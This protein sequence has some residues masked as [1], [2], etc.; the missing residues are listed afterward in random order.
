LPFVEVL[1]GCLGSFGQV[2]LRRLWPA[3]G[4]SWSFGRLAIQLH[5]YRAQGEFMSTKLI[6]I[7]F[8]L[9]AYF[10]S[11]TTAFGA[12]P[13]ASSN[14]TFEYKFEGTKFKYSVQ[15]N[16]WSSAFTQGASAC[17]EF[18]SSQR[19]PSGE[20]GID[21]IDACANPREKKGT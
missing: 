18:F 3:L 11:D 19:R 15:H 16:D 5:W 7:I 1:N 13:P 9:G 8:A 21:L 2:L 12:K 4:W 6:L 17:F 10:V 14:F 20:R